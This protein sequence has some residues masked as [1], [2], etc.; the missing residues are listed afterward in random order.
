MLILQ[1]IVS[2]RV[3]TGI[4][5]RLFRTAMSS[6]TTEKLVYRLDEVCRLSSQDGETIEAWENELG[7]IQPGRNSAGNKIYRKRDLDII[8]RLKE[9]LEEQGH[10]LAGAKR[11]IA[12]EFGL[13]SPG[14]IPQDQ[15]KQALL[16]IRQSLKELHEQL[17]D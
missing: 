10:T 7:F 16:R 3:A 9:L 12:E 11:R 4:L 1:R 13:Q 14:P 6:K 8:L 15:V 2:E 5:S 17:K